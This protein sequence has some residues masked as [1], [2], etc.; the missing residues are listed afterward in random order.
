MIVMI[1]IPTSLTTLLCY[2]IDADT[3][4][5]AVYR[6]VFIWQTSF[7]PALHW[8]DLPYQTMKRSMHVIY[9]YSANYL[10]G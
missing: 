2:G 10:S 5:I 3:N 4:Q 1:T 7:I 9:K 8:F 6:S